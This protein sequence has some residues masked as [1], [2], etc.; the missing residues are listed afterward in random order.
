ML[1]SR[2][3]GFGFGEDG[4]AHPSPTFSDSRFGTGLRPAQNLGLPTILDL[5]KQH[6]P[7]ELL[8]RGFRG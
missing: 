4:M 2:V 6:I 1:R 8:T 5:C 7:N 3:A